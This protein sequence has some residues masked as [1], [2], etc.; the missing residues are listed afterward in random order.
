M[1]LLKKQWYELNFTFNRNE[2]TTKP[3]MFP[4]KLLKAPRTLS[5]KNVVRKDE[6]EFK[7]SSHYLIR[8]SPEC[9]FSRAQKEEIYKTRN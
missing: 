6:S 7:H 8:S 5:T 9:I 4:S 2:N 3:L 1:Y